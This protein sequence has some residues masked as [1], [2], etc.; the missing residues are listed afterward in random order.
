M[1][2][3]PLPTLRGS[4]QQALYPFEMTIGCLTNITAFQNAAEQ[5]SVGRPPLYSFKLPM[6]A[7]SNSDRQDYLNFHVRSVGR[8]H[9]DIQLTLGSDVYD[10][11]TL[12][13]DQLAVAQVNNLMYNQEIQLRQVAAAN[14]STYTPP[15]VGQVYP[16]L[17]FGF[18]SA[19][20][21][22]VELPFGQSSGFLTSV[23]DSP[24][25]P[26]YAFAW[27]DPV[28]P[29]PGFPSSYLKTWKVNYPLLTDDD[30]TTVKNYFLGKQG[31]YVDF[32]FIDPTQ[33]GKVGSSIGPSDGSVIV[34]NSAGLLNGGY[35]AM[36]T[37]IVKVTSGALT[38]NGVATI[39]ITRAQAGTTAASHS[40]GDWLY[41]AYSNVRFADDNLTIKFLTVNQNSTEF[42]LVQTN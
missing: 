38:T 33:V 22:C 39:N 29:L 34:T 41:A 13:S 9:Q 37:E 5:R 16:N 11:L 23:G 6:N 2:A 31:R 15:T 28:S 4:T 26:R 32:F 10:N 27:Y 8:L 40:P 7:L 30:L 25:G 35:A 1:P 14:F 20:A 3:N 24:Y 12:M 42:S 21:A 19:G 18:G 17:K 36:G